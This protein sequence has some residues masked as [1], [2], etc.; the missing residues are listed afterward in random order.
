[1]RRILSLVA[2]L[3]VAAYLIAERTDWFTE[4][5]KSPAVRNPLYSDTLNLREKGT[6]RWDVPKDV[7]SYKEGKANLSLA[8]NIHLLREYPHDRSQVEL[9]AKVIATGSR[10]GGAKEDRLV[11]D[12][13]FKT[14]E[15]FSKAGEGLWE[16]WGH[17]WMEYGLGAVEVRPDEELRIELVVEIPDPH[18]AAGNPRLKLVGEHDHAG[19]GLQMLFFAALRDIGLGTSFACLVVLFFLAWGGKKQDAPGMASQGPA[20][21][22]R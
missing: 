3:F 19:D 10:S 20:E 18:L 13:Y 8:L 15:P 21:E 2:V 5:A 9:R 6:I 1:M 12:W 22:P 14:D 16:G 17:G 4:A 7:W 11:K